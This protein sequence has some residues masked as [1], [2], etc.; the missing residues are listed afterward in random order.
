MVYEKFA[1]SIFKVEVKVDTASI[2]DI[3]TTLLP[4]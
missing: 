3:F 4:F 2:S 1:V